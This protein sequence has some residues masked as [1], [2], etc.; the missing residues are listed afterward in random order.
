MYVVKED[1][2]QLILKF[3]RFSLLNFY[4]PNKVYER[5]TFFKKVHG[6]FE[7][8]NFS[9]LLVGPCLKNGYRKSYKEF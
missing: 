8:H 2:S 6:L 7:K 5:E 4:A 9:A 3:N 1:L